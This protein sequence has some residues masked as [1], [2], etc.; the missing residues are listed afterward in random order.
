MDELEDSR[1]L[2]ADEEL[3]FRILSAKGIPVVADYG[4]VHED[5]GPGGDTIAVP[6]Q[7]LVRG[8]GSIA[9]SR[10]ARRITDRAAPE[11]T[12]AALERL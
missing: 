8:D 7:I 4:L 2:V 6:A 9:W 3:P 11:D 1:R 12:L 10:V 5:G